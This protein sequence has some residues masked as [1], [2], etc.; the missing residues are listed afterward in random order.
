MEGIPPKL[1]DVDVPITD[2]HFA[3]SLE[4]LVIVISFFDS[5]SFINSTISL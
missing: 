2:K 5:F 4:D 1:T 3:S